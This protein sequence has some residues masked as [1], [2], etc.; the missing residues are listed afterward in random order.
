[1]RP[2]NPV[3]GLRWQAAFL[4][5]AVAIASSAL[6]GTLESNILLWALTRRG[7]SP[8][9]AYDQLFESTRADL[10]SATVDFRCNVDTSP[11]LSRRSGSSSTAL[12]WA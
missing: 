10:A 11:H 8:Q 3:Q 2:S 4:G 1:M 6:F 12:R 7:M 5:G 9:E